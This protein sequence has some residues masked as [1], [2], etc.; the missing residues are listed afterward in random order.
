MDLELLAKI[1][2]IVSIDIILSGD[3]AVVIA[4]AARKLPAEQRRWAIFGGG[5]IAIVLRIVFTLLMAFL[6][7]IPGVRLVGGVVLVW[8]T[9][10]LMLDEGGSE[11]ISTV[12]I[13]QSTWAAIRMVFVAD[14]GLRLGDMLRLA[15]AGWGD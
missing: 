2:Q 9:L 11:E 13:T 7:M 6:L 3:N 10:N 1:A 12:G 15:G 14:F 8:I 4:M 5:A